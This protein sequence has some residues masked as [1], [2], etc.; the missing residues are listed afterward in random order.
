MD[1]S[2]T[3]FKRV[4]FNDTSGLVKH[5]KTTV[6]DNR[7]VDMFKQEWKEVKPLKSRWMRLLKNHFILRSKSRHESRT[8]VDRT[9]KTRIRKFQQKLTRLTP[10]PHHARLRVGVVQVVGLKGVMFK[11]PPVMIRT[12]L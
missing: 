2:V 12:H 5:L 3:L 9:I 11:L 6:C 8:N 1:A 10:M 7:D 4:V